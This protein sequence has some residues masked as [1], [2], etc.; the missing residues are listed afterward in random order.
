MER[1]FIKETLVIIPPVFVATLCCGYPLALAFEHGLQPAYWPSSSNWF[2]VSNLDQL[3]VRLRFYLPM[4]IG[5]D[6]FFSGGGLYQVLVLLVPTLFAFYR[7]TIV[8]QGP[9][10]LRRSKNAYLGSA[11]F[12]SSEEITKLQQGLELGRDPT[13]G[14]PVR[15][16]VE[17]S[18]ITFA[19]PRTGKTSGLIL[20]NLAFS[21]PNAWS[22]PAVILDTKGE[23]YLASAARRRALGRTVVCL[24]PTGLVG[25]TDRWNPLARI[26]A[27]NVLYLQRT[28]RA[29]L[30]GGTA[31]DANGSY[32]ENRA[33][34]YLV[35]VFIAALT[36]GAPTPNLLPKLIKDKAKLI[37]TLEGLG[38]N[39]AARSTLGIL[40]AEDRVREPIE[41]SVQQALSWM[42]DPRLQALVSENS[43]DLTKLAAGE[44]DIFVTYPSSD[45]QTLAPFFRW[46]L[47]DIFGIAR[48]TTLE[49]RVVIFADEAANLGHFNEL[50]AAASELPGRGIS[51]WTFWQGRHQPEGL[52]G[53]TDAQTL[54]NLA[55]IM[56]FSDPAAAD[57][58]QLEHFSRVLGRYTAFVE[59][60]T[61]ADGRTTTN[62][63]TQ[64]I[65]LMNASD[66]AKLDSRKL[67][68]VSNSSHRA[69]RPMLLDKTVW[70]KDRRFAR[71]LTP[72]NPVA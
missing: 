51:L 8:I 44:L 38:D 33:V 14:Q 15:V 7:A 35:G 54:E 55:E 1:F 71:F 61:E 64:A 26:K 25:G 30:P 67:I 22:G 29:L 58:E 42:N 57:P 40:H 11:R 39:N 60:S 52:Y 12:A 70:Y 48:E 49:E 66:L 56:T 63:S 24:D 72:I 36:L 47:M 4:L 69:K 5:Q 18:L 21:E 31:R 50:L 34:D 9:E 6:T 59:S 53:A 68:V 16:K 10:G 17:S 23:I 20:P 28:A 41:S 45:G 65:D 43:F 27:D 62:R 32:F 2:E 3:W 46:L 19:P 13:S 37:A